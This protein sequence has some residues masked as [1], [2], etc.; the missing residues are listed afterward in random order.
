MPK[1]SVYRPTHQLHPKIPDYD[2]VDE[3][4]DVLPSVSLTVP[5]ELKVREKKRHWRLVPLAQV[6]HSP[7]AAS[8]IR[9]G[10]ASVNIVFTIICHTQ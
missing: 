6:G 1:P 7:T 9:I 2:V 10:W 3:A 5:G 4:A 8:A